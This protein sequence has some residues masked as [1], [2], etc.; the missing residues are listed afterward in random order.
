MVNGWDASTLG[1]IRQDA[2]NLV[3]LL[4]QGRLAGRAQQGLAREDD[5]RLTA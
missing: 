3:P 5:A 1:H 2:E 4:F